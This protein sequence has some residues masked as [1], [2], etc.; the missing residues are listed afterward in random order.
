MP[1]DAVYVATET[2]CVEHDGRDVVVHKDVTRVRAGHP[3]LASNPDRFRK[4][5]D[6]VHL[7]IEE[8]TAKPGGKR[9]G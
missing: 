6:A 2:F 8:A 3:I 7:D 1:N 5:D 9:G 4:A